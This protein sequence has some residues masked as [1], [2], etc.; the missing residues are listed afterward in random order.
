MTEAV[1]AML[2]G[3]QT[4]AVAEALLSAV[5]E[6]SGEEVEGG[7]A[8]LLAACEAVAG[9]IRDVAVAD[10]G[11]A[12]AEERVNS[13]QRWARENVGGSSPVPELFWTDFE[14]GRGRVLR[15]N[16]TVRVAY[17]VILNLKSIIILMSLFA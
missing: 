9:E 12:A 6:E 15:N 11:A 14:K 1:V 5:E 7:M 10:G 8:G 13:G 2:R 16:D 17:E 3:R 4:R